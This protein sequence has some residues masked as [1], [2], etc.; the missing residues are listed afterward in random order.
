MFCNLLLNALYFTV[1]HGNVDASH[2]WH[3]SKGPQ[4]VDEDR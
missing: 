4:T 1:P 2:P 3:R